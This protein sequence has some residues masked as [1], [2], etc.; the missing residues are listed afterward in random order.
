MVNLNNI[1]KSEAC[2]EFDMNISAF[3]EGKLSETVWLELE[4]HRLECRRCQAALVDEENFARLMSEIPRFDLSPDFTDKV[5]RKWRL[6]KDAVRS[7]I[8]IRTVLNIQYIFGAAILILV[9][10]PMVRIH[11]LAAS[12]NLITAF[13]R[14]PSELRE[15]FSITFSLPTWA[16]ISGLINVGQGKFFGLLGETGSALAPWAIWLW[17]ALVISVA[18][19]IWN[20]RKSGVGF[21]GQDKKANQEN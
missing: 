12:H 14:I 13:D 1:K 20:V 4:T 5:M 18:I 15:R 10:L 8:P 3:R 21:S 6:R 17:V 19:G 7:A 2:A 11:L 9:L 16:E